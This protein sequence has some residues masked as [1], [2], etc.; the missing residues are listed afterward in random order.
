MK[1][2]PCLLLL[3]FPTLIKAQAAP[4][5]NCPCIITAARRLAAAG[6]YE[7]AIDKLNA[8]KVCAPDSA[9]Q[10]DAL[11]VAMFREVNALR[12]KAE[13]AEQ[14]AHEE[15]VKARNAEFLAR[16]KELQATNSFLL[17]RANE[18]IEKRDRQAAYALLHEIW[19]TDP[20]NPGLSR[21]MLKSPPMLDLPVS[22]HAGAVTDARFSPDEQLVLTASDD[23]SAKLWTRGGQLVAV[24]PNDGPVKAITFD[25]RGN[26][27][28]T[29]GGKTLKIWD[30]QGRL[31]HTMPHHTIVL[32]ALFLPG[33][34]L[35]VSACTDGRM[36]IWQL[37]DT[38]PRRELNGHR[39]GV[40]SLRVS[41]DRQWLLSA[42]Q[43]NTAVLWTLSGDSVRTFRT[44]K[45]FLN[46]AIFSPDSKAILTISGERFLA[47]SD[48]RAILWD[49]ATGA[50][51]V[52]VRQDAPLL[53]ADFNPRSD[54]FVVAGAE[55][56]ATIYDTLGKKIGASIR[57]LSTVSRAVFSPDGK[58]IA[59][60]S[61]D[62]S[63]IISD[64]LGFNNNTI[65]G[66]T[67]GVL[68]VCFSADGK[69]LLTGSADHSF[70]IWSVADRA[71]LLKEIRHYTPVISLAFS[72]DGQLMLSC[73]QKEKR[74]ILWNA[75][76][77]ESRYT[78]F[79][80]GDLIAAW[81]SSDGKTVTTAANDGTILHSDTET[82]MIRNR[83]TAGA[84]TIDAKPC[85][86]SNRYV[87]LTAANT[88]QLH[89]PG[90]TAP[91][92]EPMLLTERPQNIAPFNAEGGV[93]CRYADGRI[94]YL[95][96]PS[97]R[98]RQPWPGLR[99]NALDPGPGPA[100]GVLA[101][102]GAVL[103]D[104]TDSGEPRLLLQANPSTAQ[105]LAALGDLIFSVRTDGKLYA[106]YQGTEFPIPAPNGKI[107]VTALSAGG[108]SA[109]IG[110]SDG[111][112]RL[113]V[114]SPTQLHTAY[115]GTLFQPLD[116]KQ[117][118]HFLNQF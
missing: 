111:S 38:T 4:C 41:P 91:E 113:I 48:N 6:N 85:P 39:Q 78:P 83:Q 7:L 89:R 67:D 12:K 24:L 87:V 88:L 53:W 108:Q 65:Y 74:A 26:L 18:R 94:E 43:D 32:D 117:K 22:R 75:I 109:S 46:L 118:D 62:K 31:L 79:N 42:S 11:I 80:S 50:E 99:F 72:H 73:A 54:Q 1:I 36:F 90:E 10:I 68:S 28:L 51:R 70:Q 100:I 34:S 104:P 9:Q 81:F 17:Y 37:A 116:A 69:A 102:G 112:I 71:S 20:H 84:M 56:Y 35:V 59:S 25:T 2:L 105:V 82:G 106:F 115:A 33:D 29:A 23:Q 114:L 3:L 44:H 61:M 60:V 15:T 86:G 97:G 96:L 30:N 77:G 13:N 14:L 107:S 103:L 5:T 16:Q 63:V 76:N 49:L 98:R 101:N 52:S 27:I 66:H 47:Q 57:H 110:M 21:V 58:K 19:K 8:A 55:N 45:S 93:L 64:S 92:A 95:D 40:V